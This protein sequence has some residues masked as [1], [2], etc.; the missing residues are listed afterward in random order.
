MGLFSKPKIP[1]IDVAALN[2]I[3]NQN[4]NTQVD[5]VGRKKQALQP[6][7]EKFRTD[8]AAFSSQIEPGAENLITRLGQDLSG[9][10]AQ[11]KLANENAVIA[12]R[13]QSFREVPELQRAIRASLSGGGL[14][15]SGAA[16]SA[17]ARPIIDAAR[18]SRDFSSGLET[19]RLANEA[20]RS[21]GLATTGFSARQD[22]LNKRLGVDEDTLNMLAEIGRTDLID[23]YNSLAGIE[24]E[25]GA[26]RLGVEQARQASEQARA[27]ASAARRGS[28][29]STVGSLGGLALGSFGGPMGAAI[30][31]QIGGQIG[32]LAGGANAT[33]FDPTLLFAMSQRQPSIAA[34]TT[35]PGSLSGRLSLL[36]TD[37]YERQRMLFGGR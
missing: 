34:N 7:T 31:S 4:R 28:L 32:G 8:R 24:S 5:I 22:A 6:L 21:E 9:V 19:S 15:G 17:I 23:E 11:E 36:P 35:S 20:R 37:P 2:R 29:F 27:A 14:S 18:A 10:G 3:I 30:G 1:G 13:E 16:R 26:A 25:A 33:P 12:N